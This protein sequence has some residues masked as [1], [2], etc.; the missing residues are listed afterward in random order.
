[1]KWPTPYF[2]RAEFACKC[3]CGFDTIDYE[4]VAACHAIRE[5]FDRKVKVTSA[6]RCPAHNKAVG[7]KPSSLHLLGRAADIMVEGVP[8]SVVQE[9]VEEQM[10]MG[11]LGSYEG[12]TH[13]DSRHG[14]A[15]W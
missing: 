12:F 6:C 2:T 9:L 7:G 5:H 11:G 4:V 14:R 10:D 13:I 8:A 1:M 15:R 3:G